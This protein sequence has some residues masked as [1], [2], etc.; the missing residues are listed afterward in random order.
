MG[1]DMVTIQNMASLLWVHW[2]SHC[3][4]KGQSLPGFLLLAQCLAKVA[5]DTPFFTDR[6]VFGNWGY[7]L[8]QNDNQENGD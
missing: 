4:K 8:K 2:S 6:T 1:I 3:Q 7:R 5:R